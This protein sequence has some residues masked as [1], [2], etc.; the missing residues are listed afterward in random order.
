MELILLKLVTGEE[1]I[2]S[3]PKF[4][5]DLVKLQDSV[6]VRNGM[7]PATG[8]AYVYFETVGFLSDDEIIEFER[9]KVVF[10]A[11]VSKGIG[12]AY[13]EY[14]EEQKTLVAS[15]KELTPNK[16]TPAP[17]AAGP[18]YSEDVIEAYFEKMTANNTVH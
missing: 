8:V 17:A 1:V 14:T 2:G 10:K 9:S 15:K 11:G 5:N 7:N 16:K 13:G 4:T 12:K 3:N 6:Y 18:G